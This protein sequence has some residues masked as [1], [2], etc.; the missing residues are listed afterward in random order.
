MPFSHNLNYIQQ[1]ITF[2]EVKTSS[3]NRINL[4]GELFYHLRRVRFLE[5]KLA[6]IIAGQILVAIEHLHKN[7]IIYRDLKPENLILDEDGHIKVIDFGLSKFMA[8]N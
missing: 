4:L 3:K 8:E 1:S 6:V 7:H 5:E 2:Q